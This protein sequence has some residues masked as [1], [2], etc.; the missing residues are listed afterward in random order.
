MVSE[1]QQTRQEVKRTL[2]WIFATIGVLAALGGITYGTLTATSASHTA[3]SASRTAERITAAIQQ[4]RKD[5][6]V[7]SC[8]ET[9]SRHDGAIKKLQA[10]YAQAEENASPT[11][12]KQLQLSYVATASLVD[13]IDPK[14]ANCMASANARVKAG[15]Q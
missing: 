8:L 5:S 9:N 10:I 12:L 7:R 4:E 13:Q 11:K 14:V 2:A 3:T 1:Q 6:I 15:T